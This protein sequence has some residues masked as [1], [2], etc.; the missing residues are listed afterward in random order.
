MQLPMCT[1]HNKGISNQWR[2]STLCLYESEVSA[3]PAPTTGN[4]P[5][6]TTLAESAQHRSVQK[7]LDQF[8]EK[9]I[10]FISLQVSL[11]KFGFGNMF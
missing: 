5:R 10:T 3:T 6:Q 9:T 2:N 7:Q 11:Q 4:M 8:W 1:F